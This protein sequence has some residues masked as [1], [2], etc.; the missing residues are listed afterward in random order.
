M[1]TLVNSYRSYYQTVGFGPGLG[2]FIRGCLTLYQLAKK[3]NYNFEIDFASHPFNDLLVNTCTC[4]YPH[5]YVPEF[6]NDNCYCIEPFI[7]SIQGE[8]YV[9]LTTHAFYNPPYHLYPID[10][11][12]RQAVVSK[13]ILQPHVQAKLNY[14]QSLLPPDYCTIHVRKGDRHNTNATID[15]V[16]DKL[17]TYVETVIVPKYHQNVLL[18]TDSVALKEKLQQLYGFHITNIAPSHVGGIQA[19]EFKPI[20]ECDNPDYMGALI[21]FLLMSRSKEIYRYSSYCWGSNFSNMCG[22]LYNIP[23]EVIG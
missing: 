9:F 3:Y 21:E 15:E 11:E 2:D 16:I 17:K 6:F 20:N 14:W 18:L 22:K 1:I 10:D 12:C 19:S 7:A 23:V 13:I 4:L 8:D 5:K